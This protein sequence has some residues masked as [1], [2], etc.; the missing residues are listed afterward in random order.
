MLTL[1]LF[2]EMKN[3]EYIIRHNAA[4]THKIQLYYQ[5]EGDESLDL[6][7]ALI[8]ICKRPEFNSF[9]LTPYSVKES[10]EKYV[11]TYG[12]FTL[13]STVFNDHLQEERHTSRPASVEVILSGRDPRFPTT[14]NWYGVTNAHAVI[15]EDWLKANSADLKLSSDRTKYIEASNLLAQ[16]IRTTTYF[17]KHHNKGNIKAVDFPL[18]SYRREDDRNTEN[19]QWFEPFLH[20]ILVW[21]LDKGHLEKL[22]LDQEVSFGDDDTWPYLQCHVTPQN[23]LTKAATTKTKILG[24]VEITDHKQIIL[25]EQHRLRI[26]LLDKFGRICP[27][28]VAR[29]NGSIKQSRC[30]YFNLDDDHVR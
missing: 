14:I 24:I 30:V 8:D 17:L 16:H 2:R 21:R 4:N 26:M 9:T 13:C 12:N 15:P 1:S 27:P 10:L 20:D 19:L 25:L 28:L 18:L 22:E 29:P 3:R 11:T 7:N 5:K 6:E 23:V